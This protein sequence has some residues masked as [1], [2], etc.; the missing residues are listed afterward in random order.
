MSKWILAFALALSGAASAADVIA[1]VTLLRD[2]GGQPGAEVEQFVPGDRMQ[3]FRIDLNTAQA[4]QHQFKVKFRAVDTTA[5][6][7]VDVVETDM[8]G[9]DIQQV[10]THVELPQD[11]P[12]GRYALELLV[13]GV[14]SGTREYQVAAE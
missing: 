8:A 2:A 13:D 7:N 9:A 1:D 14:P 4:G 5:G 6:Q 12:A 3:H 10:T 11:W